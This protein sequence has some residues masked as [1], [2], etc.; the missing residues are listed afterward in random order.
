MTQLT[1]LHSSSAK[2]ISVAWTLLTAKEN[3]E[4]I[5]AMFSE[6]MQGISW[7]N[8]SSLCHT[9]LNLRYPGPVYLAPDLKSKVKICTRGVFWWIKYQPT[10][11]SFL[12]IFGS[13]AK[14]IKWLFNFSRCGIDTPNSSENS[15]SSGKSTFYNR[16]LLPTHPSSSPKGPHQS[17][18]QRSTSQLSHQRLLSL[19]ISCST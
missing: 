18:F 7:G 11:F 10:Q 14:N 19:L 13:W 6:R 3:E 1:S 4:S 2:G 5:L 8:P 15:P 9:D 12:C 16:S 17:P